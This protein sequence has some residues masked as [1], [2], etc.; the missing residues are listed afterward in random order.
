MGGFFRLN[1]KGV[2]VTWRNAADL[3]HPCFRVLQ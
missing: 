3:Q 2:G 1:N